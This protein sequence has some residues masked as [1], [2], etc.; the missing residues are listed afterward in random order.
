MSP[1]QRDVAVTGRENGVPNRIWVDVEDLFQYSATNTRPSGIQRIEFELCRALATLAESRDR[2]GF[3]RH[4]PLQNSFS[5]IPFD[6]IDA[7]HARLTAGDSAVAPDSAAQGSPGGAAS[8]AANPGMARRIAYRIPL[9]IRVP[10]LK[11]MRAQLDTVRATG[12]LVG[13]AADQA[14]ELAR[15]SRRVQA[16]QVSRDA[17]TVASFTD[18]VATGDVLLVLG[19]TWFH[20]FYAAMLAQAR[21][22][23]GLRVAALFYDAIP[24][25]RPEWCDRN[26]VARFRHWATTLLPLADIPL[27]ISQATGQDLETFAAREAI[28]LRRKPSAIPVGTGFSC[29][30]AGSGERIA[31]SDRLPAPGSYVLAVSTIEARKNH[32]LL[33]RVWRRLLDEMPRAAVPTLVFAGK[34]GWLVED[35][36]Q[37]LRNTDRLDGRIVLID[38]PHDSELAD[39]YRGCLFTVFPSFY[40][41]WGLPVTESLGFGRPCVISNASALPEAGGT[42]ARYFDPENG[43]EAYRV[44]RRAIE[45]KEGTEA[46]AERI[47]TE[48]RPVSWD[49]SARA[50]LRTLDHT[51]PDRRTSRDLSGADLHGAAQGATQGAA[52]IQPAQA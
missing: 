52:L 18:N 51:T 50:L 45:D 12:S 35:L 36:M 28:I 26:L 2:V 3:L 8:G 46:W 49:E 43:G 23:F 24:L 5:A 4:D 30:L 40:E 34:V 31:R 20:P 37:Q 19:S 41:G 39:L 21:E 10:L 32:A 44:I 7:L 17:L 27:T 22:R 25:I 29:S 14:R 11:I 16:A 9:D 38:D 15:R 1:V 6:A 13:A 48:F 47:R 42:L 33:F